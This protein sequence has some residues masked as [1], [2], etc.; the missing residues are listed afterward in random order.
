MRDS[1]AAVP[2]SSPAQAPAN[3]PTTSDPPASQP[4]GALPSQENQG[5]PRKTKPAAA[6]GA[7][8]PP[9]GRTPGA[10]VVTLGLGLPA[11]GCPGGGFRPAPF[12][13]AVTV[14]V[15]PWAECRP[16]GIR[17]HGCAGR[18]GHGPRPVP[19][20]S[21]QDELAVRGVPTRSSSQRAATG[22]PVAVR[23]WGA[24]ASW[25]AAPRL[26]THLNRHAFLTT[27]QAMLPVPGA[28]TGYASP[29]PKTR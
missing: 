24:W 15:G 12:R 5:K 18:R 29:C 27:R 21:G 23:R 2:S 10:R 6:F 3:P 11:M 16:A 7:K 9:P 1:F 8:G 4:A 13:R 28:P 22:G 19:G 14:E 26:A 20:R 17:R 25:V